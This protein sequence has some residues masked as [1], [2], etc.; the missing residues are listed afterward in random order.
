LYERVK[1]LNDSTWG[2]N[3]NMQATMEMVLH[4]CVTKDIDPSNLI[5]AV[6]S[7]MQF[8]AA[9]GNGVWRTQYERI[10]RMYKDAGY[11]N[12]P[13]LLFWNL[14]GNP[15]SF[16]ADAHTPGVI[17]LSGFSVSLLKSFFEVCETGDIPSSSEMIHKLLYAERYQPIVNHF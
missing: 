9:N 3:T 5:I 8:D 6:F 17:M 2:Y 16:V 1:A 15:S 11:T 7:D 13:I 14:R 10:V 12:P 4:E